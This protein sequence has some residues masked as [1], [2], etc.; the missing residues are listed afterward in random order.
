MP[1]LADENLVGGHV[2]L[3]FVNTVDERLTP[4]PVE[5]LDTPSELWEWGARLGL[6]RGPVPRS[7]RSAHAE[8]SQARALRSALT[9]LFDA[10]VAARPLPP[11]AL[12]LLAAEVAAAH[13]AGRLQRRRLDS[14]IGWVWPDRDLSTVRHVCATAAA[15][16]LSG[17]LSARVRRC[18]GDGCGWFF[19]DATKAGNR[20][21][22]SMRTC[23]QDAKAAG[24]RERR[25]HPESAETA[26]GRSRH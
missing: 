18:P 19:V 8:L 10:H 16:L 9:R 13:A 11:D 12:D 15:E 23:G 17:P 20:R 6:V 25:E 2:A 21:W 22:C 5:L 7:A 4:D 26:V 1:E 14:C 3:D 24:R